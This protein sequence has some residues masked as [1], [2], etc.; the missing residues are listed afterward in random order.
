MS[1]ERVGLTIWRSRA[2]VQLW[3]IVGFV[4]GRPEFKFSSSFFKNSQLVVSC[5][6]GIFVSV[7]I[8]F[9]YYLACSRSS[10]GGAQRYDVGSERVKSYAGKN[11]GR[12]WRVLFFP[13]I[14]R[15]R[16]SIRP[17]GTG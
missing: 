8:I 7:W 12:L 2:R 11:K 6:L 16:S 10:D 3:R 4:V 13:S 17:P 5:Q 9:S 1:G 14:F 15:P